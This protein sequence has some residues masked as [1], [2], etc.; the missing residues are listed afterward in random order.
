MS[1]MLWFAMGSKKLGSLEM[2]K[3]KKVWARQ[4]LVSGYC[5]A[6]DKMAMHKPGSCN[7]RVWIVDL[8]EEKHSVMQKLSAAL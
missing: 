3:K 7:G 6:G 5:M 4:R 1:T 8:H 2:V